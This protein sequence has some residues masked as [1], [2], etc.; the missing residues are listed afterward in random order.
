MCYNLITKDETLFIA[1]CVL[2]FILSI[3]MNTVVVV[4]SYLAPYVRFLFHKFSRQLYI[5]IVSESHIAIEQRRH[6]E[7]IHHILPESRHQGIWREGVMYCYLFLFVFLYSRF[8]LWTTEKHAQFLLI[9]T[10]IQR[11]KPFPY[12]ITQRFL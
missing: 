5:N 2:V 6:L 10:N 1:S 7:Y 11:N 3:H 8:F 9:D 12:F 4:Y